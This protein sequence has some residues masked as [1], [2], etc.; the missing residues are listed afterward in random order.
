MASGSIK[1]EA[2]GTWMFVVDIKDETGKRKQ[3]RRRGFKSRKEAQAELTKLLN[4]VNDG[5]YIE[6]V[7]TTLGEY[8]L[9][10]LDSKH[11]NMS[12]LTID[13]YRSYI[14]NHVAPS[15]GHVAL[16]KLSPLDIQ[17][18]VTDLRS[19]KD[20]KG[21]SLSASTI[22][23]IFNIVVT[24]LNNAKKMQ[25]IKENVAKLIDKPKIKKKKIEVWD[26][27]EIR[28]FLDGMYD[29][30]HYI[31]FHLALL[32]GMR[33]GEILGLSWKNIDYEK[34]LIHVTQTLS[35]DRKEINHGAKS[36]AGVRSISINEKDVAE[37]KRHAH[38]IEE[39]KEKAGEELYEDRGLVVCTNIG[40]PVFA[41]TIGKMFRKYYRKFN[42]TPIRFHDLRH[43]HASLLLKQ[44]VHPKIVSERLGHSSVTITLDTYSHLLPNMQEEA[45]SGLGNL[46][47]SD[48]QKNEL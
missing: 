30:R 11:D 35:H 33:Q 40:R 48:P 39:E 32:T 29:N 27:D 43:T 42:V 8:M 17:K 9:T 13:S 22:Q 1:K 45:A 5:T 36:H 23:R 14:K 3:K 21:R 24:S 2:N 28:V 19:K 6:P 10:W 37:L 41:D 18:L 47:F 46:I 44:G 34:K 4:D 38:R 20:H 26:V 31:C 25:L 7:K 12:R 15:I 16:S